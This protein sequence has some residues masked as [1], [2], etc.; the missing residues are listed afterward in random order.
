MAFPIFLLLKRLRNE[1][2]IKPDENYRSEAGHHVC[3]QMQACEV[4]WSK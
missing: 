1:L 4:G 2:Y 3:P